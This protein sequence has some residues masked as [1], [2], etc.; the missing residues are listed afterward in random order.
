VAIK[1]LPK[2]S[3]NLARYIGST[4]FKNGGDIR[5]VISIG[6]LI[7]KADGPSEVDQI[8]KT[9]TKYGVANDD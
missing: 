4:V 1:V 9:M 3:E 2:V 5:D 8:I 7:R 6:K